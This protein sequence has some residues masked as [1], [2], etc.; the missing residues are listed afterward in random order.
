MQS[1]LFELIR[2]GFFPGTHSLEAIVIAKTIKGTVVIL[3][4]YGIFREITKT[5]R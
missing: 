2:T 5:L 1:P 3:M 4:T